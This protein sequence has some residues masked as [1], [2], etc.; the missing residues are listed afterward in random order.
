MS[1]K[2]NGPAKEKDGTPSRASGRIPWGDLSAF[3]AIARQGGLSAAAR[4]IG[5]SAPTLGRRMRAME[6]A[7]GRELFVHRS[8]GYDLT[9][10][11]AQLRDRL[12]PVEDIIARATLPAS[13][14]ALPLVKISAGTWTALALTAVLRSITGD[15]P[16]LRVRLLQG[17]DVLSIPR[18]EAAIGFRSRRPTD[19][20]LA[21][22]RIQRVE[23]APFAT[24][25]APDDWIVVRADTPS[26]H[27]VAERCGDGIAVEAN[28]PRL[29]LDLALSGFGRAMLPT[30]LGDRQAG[31][32]RTGPVVDDLAH[33]QWLVSHDDDRDLPEI[34]R[35][36]D[37]IG[38]AF[39]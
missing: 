8:H 28:S 26:A 25:D 18:R 6:R 5:S 20:G 39:G 35:A 14:G 11:G 9:A 31:L 30:F 12:L 34:R 2:K 7:L 33:D 29:A 23:F 3:L 4:D 19:T 36:L 1:E 17:E 16:D 27:W 24:A 13:D 21:G 37:R 15:P 22:R 38:R 32:E 10:E